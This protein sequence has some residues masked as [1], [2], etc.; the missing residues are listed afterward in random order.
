MHIQ[1]MGTYILDMERYGHILD[2]HIQ[3]MTTISCDMGPIS[4][5]MAIS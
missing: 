5:D 4:C 1:D 3:D 2:M